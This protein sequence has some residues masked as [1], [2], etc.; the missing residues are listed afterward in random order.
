MEPLDVFSLFW[1][2]SDTL[3]LPYMPSGKLIQCITI[4]SISVLSGLKSQLVDSENSTSDNKWVF[5]FIF[6]IIY[7][8]LCLISL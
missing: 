6:N 4:A 5:L 8:T 2:R 7:I 1:N 3:S